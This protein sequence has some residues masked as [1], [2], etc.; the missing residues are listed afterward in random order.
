MRLPIQSAGV[1]RVGSGV[2]AVGTGGVIPQILF[3]TRLTEAER[4]YYGYRSSGVPDLLARFFCGL[5]PFTIGGLLIPDR[6]GI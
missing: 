1:N 2:S 4:C 3:D 6:L 5:R